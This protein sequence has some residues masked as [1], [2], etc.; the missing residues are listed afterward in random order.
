MRLPDVR[1][2][3]G[4]PIAGST[5]RLVERVKASP[6]WP[7]TSSGAERVPQHSP[8]LGLDAWSGRPMMA[9]RIASGNPLD[10]L[11]GGDAHVT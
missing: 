9:L 8:T 6:G 2:P 5:G 1:T 10:H 3:G 11:C 7:C 4:Y